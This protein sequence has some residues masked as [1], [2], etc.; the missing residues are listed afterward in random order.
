MIPGSSTKSSSLTVPGPAR[1]AVLTELERV[2]AS[3]TLRGSA[4][5]LR[6][7]RFLVGEALEGRG[8]DLRAAVLATRVLDRPEGFDT[9]VD[10]IVRVEMSKLRRAL[11]SHYALAGAAALRI[12]L[13]RGSYA[14]IFVPALDS[15]PPRSGERPAAGAP[16]SAPLTADGPV[17]AVLPFM[18][19][20]AVSTTSLS[21]A[22]PGAGPPSA[23]T[24]SRAFARG[25]SDRLGALFA[26]TPCVTVTSHVSTLEEAAARGARYVLEGTVRILPGALRVDAKLHDTRRWVQVWG[27]RYDRVV[28]DDR[29]FAVEEEIARAITTQLVLLP[30]GDI[31]AIEAEDRTGDTPRS[32]Y[33]LVLLFRRWFA[34]FDPR[35][36]VEIA[37]ACERHLAVAPDDGVVLAFSSYFHLLSTWT[38]LGR[39]DQDRRRATDHARR[40][41]LSAPTLPSSHQALACALLDA[42]DGR[43]AL[44]EAEVALS[45]G[46]PLTLTGLVLAL[47]GDWERGVGVIRTHMA[48]MQRHP[49]AIRHAFA[50]DA[51]RRGDHASALAEADAIATPN[52]A[53]APLDR[54]VA[55][56]RLGRISEAR[57]AGRALA[58]MLPSIMEDPRAVLARLT[59]DEALIRDLMEALRLAGV[60]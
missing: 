40:A 21:V 14:P 48:L 25:L 34:T 11:A 51:Y 35:V 47:A 29:L 1:A 12:E 60:G 53:W 59:A 43:G 27:N 41:V 22:T 57:A 20:D 23:G 56:A 19:I 30:Q 3:P 16:A 9:T 7:L 45:M 37:E 54:A 39:G 18:P 49:G 15:Q 8:G 31:H 38:A 58:A 36:H 4:R 50:L 33:E 17:L 52:L 32:A 5:Q 13:P 6:L 46:G 44:A 24:R 42:G 55:L 2:A 26:C 10:S 28:A